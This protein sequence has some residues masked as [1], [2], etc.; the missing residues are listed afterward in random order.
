MRPRHPEQGV[1]TPSLR[2]EAGPPPARRIPTGQL[3][4]CS[5]AEDGPFDTEA[6]TV[7]VAHH[8]FWHT[9]YPKPLIAATYGAVVERIRVRLLTDNPDMARSEARTRAHRLVGMAL[10]VHNSPVTL[11]RPDRYPFTTLV[12][13]GRQP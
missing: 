12:L 6:V 3:L 10:E 2:P 9:A 8:G 7:Y 5:P 11:T 13:S 4:F 1:S